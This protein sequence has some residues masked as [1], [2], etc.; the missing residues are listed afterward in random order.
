MPEKYEADGN[1]TAR[2]LF[3]VLCEVLATEKLVSLPIKP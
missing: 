3:F 2:P 1:F